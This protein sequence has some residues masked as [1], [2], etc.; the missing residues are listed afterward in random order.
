MK[1]RYFLASIVCCYTF[2]CVQAQGQTLE[3]RLADFLKDKKAAVGV[4]VLTDKNEV[5]LHGNSV[6]YPLLSVFKFHVA[7]A[8]LDKM[9]RGNIALDSIVHVKVSQLHPDTYSP[10]R[11]K[12]P[13]QDVD[14]S[15]KELL[16][17]S[18]SLSDNNVCDILI[19]QAG[20]IKQVNDYIKSLG[21]NDFNLSETEVSMHLAPQESPYLN[22]STPEEMV[23]L[24]KI[25]DERTLFRPQYK[26]FLWQT[27]METST[28]NNKLKGL[29][30]PDVA[31]GHKTGS[32][33]RTPDGVKI[34]DNNAGLVILPDG[35]K[36]YIAVFVMDSRETDE[37]NAAIIAGVSRIVYDDRVE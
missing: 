10:L 33:D 13:N 37:D 31:V 20:G 9:D 25:A 21:V 5:V 36:Y 11:Q 2:A 19:E 6:H 8:V 14:I 32:S 16:Q 34:A 15:L 28:G 27:M 26:D 35:R 22:W 1:I 24:L 3:S 29:L 12:Y 17:Y 18:I 4:A 30:P 7:L 23:R